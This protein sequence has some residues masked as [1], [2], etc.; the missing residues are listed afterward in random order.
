MFFFSQKYCAFS[1]HEMYCLNDDVR[2]SVVPYRDDKS[3]SLFFFFLSS[4]RSFLGRSYTMYIH[5]YCIAIPATSMWYTFILSPW[6]SWVRSY[7]IF[8]FNDTWMTGNFHLP[9]YAQLYI[10]TSCPRV[11]C[12]VRGERKHEDRRF[13]F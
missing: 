7:M 11:E 4:L 3:P 12:S 10:P 6:L 9:S 8:L 2:S 1:L 5:I 13:C